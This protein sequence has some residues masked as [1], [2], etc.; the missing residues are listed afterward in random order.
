MCVCVCVCEGERERKME[1]VT[2]KISYLEL[3]EGTLAFQYIDMGP[4]K[5]I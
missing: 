5:S 4:R 1:E 3:P 2:M